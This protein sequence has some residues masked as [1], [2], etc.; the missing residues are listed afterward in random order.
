MAEQ[1]FSKGKSASKKNFG[2]MSGSSD[3]IQSSYFRGRK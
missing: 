1:Y 3:L 2:K